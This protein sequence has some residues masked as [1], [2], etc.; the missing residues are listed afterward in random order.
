MGKYDGGSWHNDSIVL[1]YHFTGRRPTIEDFA[2]FIKDFERFYNQYEHDYDI[3]GAYF[4][5]YEEYDKKAFNLLLRNMDEDLRVFIQIK[6]LEE[7]IHVSPAGKVV[8]EHMRSKEYL[9]LTEQKSRARKL[10][11]LP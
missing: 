11:S 6:M 1:I 8:P 4:V 2:G 10:C 7:K 3:D 5:V 9:P